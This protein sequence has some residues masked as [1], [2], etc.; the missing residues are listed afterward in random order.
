[1][2]QPQPDARGVAA[3]QSLCQPGRIGDLASPSLC[4]VV[5]LA[6]AFLSASACPALSHAMNTN[7]ANA[8]RA[9]AYAL[10]KK[11]NARAI[12]FGEMATTGE[13]SAA[14]KKH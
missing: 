12:Y 7:R 4:S 5:R 9:P 13:C 2:Q 6:A 1:M 11:G 14:T 8:P 10:A 3:P